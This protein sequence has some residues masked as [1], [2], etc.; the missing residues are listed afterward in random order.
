MYQRKLARLKLDRDA[1]GLSSLLEKISHVQVKDCFQEDGVLVFLVEE[2]N[3]KKALGKDS[4]NIDRISKIL[5]KDI[6]IIAFS[7]DICK[8]VSNL[9][10][11]NKADEIKL[12]GKTVFI[13]ASDVGV[14]GRIFGRSRENLKRINSLVRNYFDVEEVK[15]V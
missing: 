1:L 2:G 7:N 6:K 10:Y 8:F 3:V 13:V 5:K 14:K 4:S 12:E 9:I 11:P 15:V